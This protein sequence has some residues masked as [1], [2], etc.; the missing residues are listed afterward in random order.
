MTTLRVADEI[1][2]RFPEVVLGV[3]T[4]HGIDNS[5]EDGSVLARLRAEEALARER[6]SGVQI[7][8]HPHIAPWREAYRAFG[9]KPK[10]YPSSIENLV[11]RVAKGHVLPQIN[12]L[13]DI[14]NAVSLRHV[15]PVGGEDLDAVRGDVV[16]AFAGEAEAAVTLLG[17]AEAR[18]PRPGEVIY[19]DD[20]GALCRRWNWK[21]A[22]RTKLTPATRNA[23]LVIEGLPPVG[24]ELVERATAELA[25]AIR[26]FCG[27]HV[28]IGT[29]DRG[30]R[31]MSLCDPS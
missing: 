26:T 16:L 2:A 13:V 23:F 8:E 21:E 5:R 31:E 6:F 18:A 20:D 12:T 28:G 29:I 11:R 24:A 1:F 9:A 22:D 19:K 3:V 27:G 30:R 10:D 7:T 25:E 15:V 4:A 14:Y 17:E